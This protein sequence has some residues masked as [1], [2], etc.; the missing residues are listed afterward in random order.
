MGDLEKLLICAG[1][2][3][4]LT[5]LLGLIVVPL[6][7]RAK[8]G[9]A[10]KEDGPVWHMSKQGTPTVGGVMFILPAAVVCL[11]WGLW[12]RDWN[13]MAVFGFAAVFGLIGCVDD[14]AKLRHHQNTGLSAPMKFLLQ[15]AAAS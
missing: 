1:L 4:G 10:I 3:F 8:V 15:L 7:R 13:P 14:V 6:L 12:Q 11:M 9:Q 5:A 2:G